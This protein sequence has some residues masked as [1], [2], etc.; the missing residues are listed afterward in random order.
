MHWKK[1]LINTI[2]TIGVASPLVAMIAVGSNSRPSTASSSYLM[3]FAE[4]TNEYEYVQNL[5]KQVAEVFAEYK[6]KNPEFKG[7]ELEFITLKATLTA[8][9]INFFSELNK[10]LMGI[11]ENLSF[12]LTQRNPLTLKQGYYDRNVDM[13]SFYWSPDYNGIGTWL[14]YVFAEYQVPNL[15]P[16]LAS[17]INQNTTNNDA[18]NWVVSLRE[19]L[20]NFSFE[21]STG[22]IPIVDPTTKKAITYE[23]ILIEGAKIKNSNPK[24]DWTINKVNSTIGNGVGAWA[25]NHL[26][27]STGTLNN[28]PTAI[29]NGLYN[30][31]EGG[32]V[33]NTFKPS[34]PVEMLNFLA[35]FRPNLPYIQDGGNSINATLLRKGAHLPANPNSNPNYR[36]YYRDP[37]FNRQVF[38][39]RITSDP[40]LSTISPFNPT[41]TK[42]SSTTF[43]SV[44][45][46]LFS[47]ST[48][49]DYYSSE[50]PNNQGIDI[51]DDF[52]IALTSFGTSLTLD[53]FVQQFEALFNP[54][55]S[56]KDQTKS[57]V[58]LP[59][60]AIPW[61]NSK[62]QTTTDVKYLS[63]Q[64]FLAGFIGYGQSVK[65]K[66]NK[67]DY[68]L[69]LTNIDIEKTIK[70]QVNTQRN[71][72]STEKKPFRIH[73]KKKELGARNIADILSSQYFNALPAFSQKV[74]NII[75]PQLFKKYAV[76]DEKGILDTNKSQMIEFYGN[77]AGKDPRVWAELWSASPYYISEVNDT[78]YVF[79]KN[80][81]FFDF[82][83]K[84]IQAM[85][86]KDNPDNYKSYKNSYQ[87]N[88]KNVEKIKTFQITYGDN[89][90]EQ[91]TY[92]QFKAGQLDASTI[93][94]ALKNEVYQ[95]SLKENIYYAPVTKVNKSDL[96]PYNLQ[97]YQN[98]IDGIPKFENNSDRLETLKKLK[99]DRYGNTIYPEDNKPV[100]K[101]KLTP[102][103]ID[104]IVKNFYTPINGVDDNGQLLPAIERSSSIIRSA[105]NDCINW[106][107]INS[108]ISPDVTRSF[109]NSFFPFGVAKMNNDQTLDARWD[110]WNLAA[111][112]IGQKDKKLGERLGGIIQW[113]L[114][115]LLKSWER[116]A[117]NKPSN[118]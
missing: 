74:K 66:F 35:S 53:D 106:M 3:N 82:F 56:L 69:N 115:E 25:N 41:F 9:E 78:T 81:K 90:K 87:V 84:E 103:Y 7:L 104:L 21:G 85:T 99:S 37:E 91:I 8:G 47:W 93:P 67:N 45:T 118:K 39:Q 51:R 52:K 64:D 114:P 68:F 112:K 97:V 58:E 60:R 20:T 96:I 76:L 1:L 101:T 110:Y 95:T 102:G 16:G 5:K 65:V 86:A 31:F 19:Y 29:K 12:K 48:T 59:I 11:N 73:F 40:F 80:Q 92:E 71:T 63:P 14:T 46:P 117:S 17:I 55:G 4:K 34:K 109:Q 15:W 50:K 28:D 105:I 72:T 75:D 49:G 54:D 27:E 13:T 113:T 6:K 26:Q 44:Y 24:S 107:S 98:E 79:E 36:D 33:Q 10:A 111:Y 22:K 89:Y 83:E 61:V 108:L 88:N 100:T 57:Y 23:A 70:D 18:N 43:H 116:Q 32:F 2:V 77:G 94:T 30:S 42:T 62:G 38:K